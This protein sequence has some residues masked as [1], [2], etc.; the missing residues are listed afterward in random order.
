MG[1]GLPGLARRV[2]WSQEVGDAV[3]GEVRAKALSIRRQRCA[4][5]N[6]AFPVKTSCCEHT[7]LGSC[8]QAREGIFWYLNSRMPLVRSLTGR[9]CFL[10]DDFSAAALLCH[11]LLPP[12]C[13]AAGSCGDRDGRGVP[14]M[15]GLFPGAFLRCQV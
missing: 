10:R 8:W 13:S 9:F 12:S 3:L 7:C 1:V 6:P 14:A 11:A 2:A 5:T 15:A 4:G